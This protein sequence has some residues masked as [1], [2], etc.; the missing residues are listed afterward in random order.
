MDDKSKFWF[1]VLVLMLLL[2]NLFA[3]V[4]MNPHSHLSCCHDCNNS[5]NRVH[6]CTECS[7]SHDK[8]FSQISQLSSRLDALERQKTGSKSILGDNR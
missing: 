2:A 4:V 7:L 1:S 5:T 8:L 3:T 6:C